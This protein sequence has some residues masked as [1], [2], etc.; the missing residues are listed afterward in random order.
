MRGYIFLFC[1]RQ[2]HESIR[3][4]DDTT[5]FDLVM[6]ILFEQMHNV[7]LIAPSTASNCLY[8]ADDQSSCIW[9]LSLEDHQVTKWFCSPVLLWGF[10]VST[11]GQVVV[12]QGN[13]TY[14]ATFLEIYSS[15]A[16]LIRRIELLDIW[17]PITR[18]LE[19]DN[20]WHHVSIINLVAAIGRVI[21]PVNATGTFSD[22]PTNITLRSIRSDT[23]KMNWF[24]SS[25]Y[26]E[27][28]FYHY[29]CTYLIS[30]ETHITL[31]ASWNEIEYLPCE[32]NSICL[33]AKFT[34]VVSVR[35]YGINLARYQCK[36]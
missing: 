36:V 6:L 31:L 11:D 10:T 15:D 23:Y 28:S 25:Y 12:V 17:V 35:S 3:V 22:P 29:N 14:M 1:G 8:F 32:Y 19:P 27:Y 26:L 16:V 33:S 5:P 7:S 24:D 2:F 9:R 30:E 4:F 34:L 18:I 20:L 21:G 13:E